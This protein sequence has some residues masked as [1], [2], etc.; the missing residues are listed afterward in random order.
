MRP[1][2]SALNFD[3]QS[4]MQA[5]G[6]RGGMALLGR[7]SPVLRW[8]LLTSTVTTLAVLLLPDPEQDRVAGTVE[9]PG[10]LAGVAQPAPADVPAASASAGSIWRSYAA[11]VPPEFTEAERDP[12][13]REPSAAPAA[14]A[15]QIPTQPPPALRAAPALQFRVAGWF[16]VGGEG[17]LVLLTDGRTEVVAKQGLSLPDGFVVQSIEA[18]SLLLRHHDTQTD[19]VLSLPASL[20]ESR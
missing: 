11:R 5:V 7:L 20:A 15:V 18:Q 12:F 19:Y 2:T 9:P 1:R 10:G 8:A 17:R 16:A 14:V 3:Q 4:K 6:W 13:M